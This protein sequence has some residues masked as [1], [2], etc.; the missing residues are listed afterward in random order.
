MKITSLRRFFSEGGKER[1][2]LDY[3]SEGVQIVQLLSNGHFVKPIPHLCLSRKTLKR[4]VI[5]TPEFLDLLE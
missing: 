3:I 5:G 1:K 4:N 2:I